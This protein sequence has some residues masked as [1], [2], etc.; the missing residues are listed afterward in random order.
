MR[1]TSFFLSVLWLISSFSAATAVPRSTSRKANRRSM[2]NATCRL[3]SAARPVATLARAS[4]WAAAAWAATARCS[5]RS[6]PSA[7][8]PARS[9]SSLARKAKVDARSS[10]RHVSWPPRPKRTFSSWNTKHPPHGGCFRI[11]KN[12]I[13]TSVQQKSP[14]LILALGTLGLVVGYGAV[15]AKS[16]TAFANAQSCPFKNTP[17]A[18]VGSDCPHNG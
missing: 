5:T 8:R 4:A 2:P 10:A 15:V 17:T 3:P 14:W 9:R 6:A 13:L 16:G 12:A 11:T 1:L 7:A 18:C